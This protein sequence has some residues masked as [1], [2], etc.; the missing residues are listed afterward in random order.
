MNEILLRNIE[1][2]DL[3]SYRYWKDPAHEHHRYNG[4]YFKRMSGPELDDFI[5]ELASRLRDHAADALPGRKM[6]VDLWTDDLIG[7]VNWYWKS[8]ETRWMEVGLVIFDNRYWGKGLGASILVR[9]MDE[10][11]ERFPD[12]VRLGL[13]TWSG[14]ARMMHLA[15]KVGLVQEA[16]YRKARIVDDEYYDSLSYGILREEWQALG[17]GR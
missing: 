13:T 3:A 4:P 7:E 2:K 11:F 1:L 12:L 15:T 14:N 10:L 17:H 9:W 6:V 5:D 16:C 8:E